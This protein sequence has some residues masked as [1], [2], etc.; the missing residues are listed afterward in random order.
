MGAGGKVNPKYYILEN[1]KSA[2]KLMRECQAGIGV[3]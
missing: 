2:Q 1:K 3:S